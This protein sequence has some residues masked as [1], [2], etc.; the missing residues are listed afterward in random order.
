MTKQC[1]T[2]SSKWLEESLPYY[3][4]AGYNILIS[5]APGIGKSA[6]VE[7]QAEACGMD[8]FVESLPL[9]DPTDLKGLPM[10]SNNIGTALIVLAKVMLQMQKNISIDALSEEIERLSSSQSADF[11]P[12]KNV[13]RWINAKKPSVVNFDDFGQAQGSVQAASMQPLYSRY[14]GHRKISDEVR[15]VIT[16]NRMEDLAHVVQGVLEPVKSR[17]TTMLELVPYAPDVLEYFNK[18]KF[19]M[20]VIGF[21]RYRE[22]LVS[23]FKPT[24]EMV[25]S[26]C[27]RTW[28]AVSKIMNLD[29]PQ[30]LLQANIC[31]A[32][33][34]GAGNEFLGF[35]ELKNVLVQKE[36]IFKDPHKATI[37]TEISHLYALCALLINN[38]T[39]KTIEPILIYSAR[40]PGEFSVMIAKDIVTREKKLAT[41]PAFVKWIKQ[42]SHIILGE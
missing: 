42:H 35:L 17:M 19:H 25:N 8:Y 40:L 1:N 24:K 30:H 10:P 37:P 34:D 18:Q 2:V 22:D 38:A 14:I 5:G 28:E 7:Q 12:F 41:N 3:L 26:P 13:E 27:P 6:I 4:K 9:N 21:L 20:D 39:P 15:F 36:E 11:V 32:V 33:G 23:A 31:G 16:T 29:L